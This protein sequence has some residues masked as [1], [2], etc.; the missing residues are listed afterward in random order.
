LQQPRHQLS[1]NARCKGHGKGQGKAQERTN[2]CML[3]RRL[4]EHKQPAP[5]VRPQTSSVLSSTYHQT[6]HPHPNHHTHTPT[7][8]LLNSFL[9]SCCFCIREG[10]TTPLPPLP[11]C[12]TSS[13]SPG[14]S[15]SPSTCSSSSQHLAKHHTQQTLCVCCLTCMCQQAEAALHRQLLISTAH[16]P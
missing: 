5:T 11:P 8:A 10:A 14:C 9:S 4:A 13:R 15:T 3:C 2:E 12:A 1:V 7:C 6:R 16:L